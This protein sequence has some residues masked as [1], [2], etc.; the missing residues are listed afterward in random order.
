MFPKEQQTVTESAT[1]RPGVFSL[2][3]LLIFVT[4]FCILLNSVMWLGEGVLVIAAVICMFLFIAFEGRFR[5]LANIIVLAGMPCFL[6]ALYVLP[7]AESSH[8]KQTARIQVLV[9]DA[10]DSRPLRGARISLQTEMERRYAKNDPES[11]P[12][13]KA[14]STKEDGIVAVNV[15]CY[16]R[17]FVATSPLKRFS[18]Q[19]YSGSS[20]DYLIIVANEY[21]EMEV[22]LEQHVRELQEALQGREVTITVRMQR[23]TTLQG[24]DADSGKSGKHP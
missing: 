6:C 12:V 18:R 21:N 15:E 3:E 22:P 20:N 17:K 23:R 19:E 14:Y 16:V 7:S 10:L 8:G 2:G 9:V 5:R 24:H 1:S 13:K 4:V 11:N